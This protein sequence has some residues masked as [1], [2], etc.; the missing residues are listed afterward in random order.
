MAFEGT[1]QCEF[2]EL[3]SNHI[4]GN[5]YRN[6]LSTVMNGDRVSDKLRENGRGARPGLQHLL[7]ILFIHSHDTVEKLLFNVG[8]LLQASA[9][10]YSPYLITLLRVSTLDNELVGS[11]LLV[12]GLVTK[13][14]LTPRSHR[15][16][17][18]N[19]GL[20]LTTAVRVI[21]GV[22]YGTANGGT[23]TLMT[24]LTGLTKLNG[25]VLN[26]TNLADRC[27]ALKTNDANLTGGKTNLSGAVFLCHQLCECTC[28]TNQLSALAGI[29]L[30]V[31]DDSTYG[32]CGDRKHVT[33]LDI[34]ISTGSNNVAVLQAN[35]SDDVALL[36]LI[37]LKESDVGG[38]V[39]VVLN[40]DNLCSL[41]NVSLEVDDSVL[42]LVSAAVMTNGDLAVAVS[43]GSLL[44]LSEQALFGRKLSNLV[45]GRA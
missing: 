28:G 38:S 42:L 29:K 19:R 34:G 13:S 8:G 45:E 31:V 25:L 21:A 37:V 22:H 11:C 9:H 4:L 15:S 40:A 23:D 27:L 5:V 2:A 44:L 16:G 18:S 43:A 32:N 35:R 41:I 7:L 30:D 12:S 14:R 10:C 1:G 20:T 26:V 33:G 36:A 24:G 3:L 39:G 17:T 6:M